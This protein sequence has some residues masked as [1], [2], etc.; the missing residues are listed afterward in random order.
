LFGIDTLVFALSPQDR[1]VIP[2]QTKLLSDGHDRQAQ[3]DK[4]TPEQPNHADRPAPSSDSETSIPQI[5]AASYSILRRQSHDRGV[6][7]ERDR[8]PD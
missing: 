7:E 1:S 6:Q 4:T 3:H 5:N 2:S 8:V